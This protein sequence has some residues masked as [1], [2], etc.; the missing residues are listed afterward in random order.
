[1]EIH[2][3]LTDLLLSVRTLFENYIFKDRNLI[4]AYSF[5]LANKTFDLARW[6]GKSN[7]DLPAVIVNVNDD[8]YTFGERTNVINHT[9]CP[10]Y[11]QIP[12]IHDLSNPNNIKS[13]YLQEEHMTVVRP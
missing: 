11:N 9:S 13:V 5:S 1:M 2:N 6:G 3:F 7:Y 8:N 10:N 4:Q 12:V